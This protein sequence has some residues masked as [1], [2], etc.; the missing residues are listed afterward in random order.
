[1]R[2]CPACSTDKKDDD[3]DV[4]RRI[5]RRCVYD[6]RNLHRRMRYATDSSYRQAIKDCRHTKTEKCVS[7][8]EVRFVYARI[9]TGP[10]CEICHSRQKPEHWFS[11]YKKGAKSRKLEWNLSFEEFLVFWQLPCFYCGS[12]TETVGIDRVLNT[13]GYRPGNCVPCCAV[14]NRAKNNMTLEAFLEWVG[15]LTNRARQF[16]MPTEQELIKVFSP[17]ITTGR[18]REAQTS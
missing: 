14:C 11:H 9:E 18:S 3:F 10:Q 13:A 5:C 12:E 17:V 16:H 1:M 7:C 15:R 8:G 4:G 6:R 2:F